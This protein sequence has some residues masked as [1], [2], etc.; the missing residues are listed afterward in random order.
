MKSFAQKDRAFSQHESAGGASKRKSEDTG[1]SKTSLQRM[2]DQSPKVL[3]LIQLQDALNQRKGSGGTAPVQ[4]KPVPM[5]PMNT[6]I[7]SLYQDDEIGIRLTKLNEKGGFLFRES[8]ILFWDGKRYLS[9]EGKAVDPL[10]LPDTGRRVLDITQGELGLVRHDDNPMGYTHLRT[11]NASPCIILSLHYPHERKSLMAHIHRGNTDEQI[12]QLM[13]SVPNRDTVQVRLITKDYGGEDQREREIQNE[14]YDKLN[15]HFSS[16]DKIDYQTTRDQENATLEMDTGSVTRHPDNPDPVDLGFLSTVRAFR[17]EKRYQQD[18]SLLFE[19]RTGNA[20]FTDDAYELMAPGK[21]LGAVGQDIFASKQLKAKPGATLQRKQTQDGSG[22]FDDF[23]GAYVTKTPTDKTLMGQPVFTLQEAPTGDQ[24]VYVEVDGKDHYQPFVGNRVG[25]ALAQIRNRLLTTEQEGEVPRQIDGRDVGINP[26]A[27]Y[28]IFEDHTDSRT[29]EF[30]EKL[31]M[32]WLDEGAHSFAPGID[33][34]LQTVFG[35]FFKLDFK[36]TVLQQSGGNQLV[37]EDLIAKSMMKFHLAATQIVQGK[38]ASDSVVQAIR[39]Y[40]TLRSIGDVL[41]M[42]KNPALINSLQSTGIDVTA[43]ND[44]TEN[45]EIAKFAFQNPKLCFDLFTRLIR[46]L[47]TF[48]SKNIEDPSEETSEAL[49]SLTQDRS[50][51]YGEESFTNHSSTADI[52]AL[53][54]HYMA[55]N[56]RAAQAPVLVRVGSEHSDGLIRELS[57]QDDIVFLKDYQEFLELVS[58]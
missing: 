23:L 9:N 44:K 15:S 37:L 42:G 6:D 49:Q 7:G 47:A 2:V 8:V 53:R 11:S 21:Q 16:M 22:L 18:K 52:N 45:S 17:N 32:R 20:D 43:V 36:G 51:E 12:D 41:K 10:A 57:G 1:S 40:F 38:A 13:N 58:R 19:V 4:R 25:Q 29:V 5:D 34:M 35:N 3:S 14:R 56:I 46:A 30:A 33:D 50:A 55:R 28:V 26:N 39:R 54:D 27:K 31:G 48:K 24:W